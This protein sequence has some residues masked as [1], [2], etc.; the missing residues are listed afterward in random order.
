[1]DNGNLLLLISVGGLYVS[2]NGLTRVQ[3]LSATGKWRSAEASTIIRLKALGEIK[4]ET[5]V[6]ESAIE[7]GVP[8]AVHSATRDHFTDEDRAP[9]ESEPEAL[10]EAEPAVES[11][12]SH[13]TS[14]DAQA[15]VE[16]KAEAEAEPEAEADGED[17]GQPGVAAVA[18]SRQAR[19]GAAADA[20]AGLAEAGPAEPAPVEKPAPAAAAKPKPPASGMKAPAARPASAPRST[21][22][23][24]TGPSSRS[25]V[26]T[27]PPPWKILATVGVVSAAILL[28]LS[29]VNNLGQS[30]PAPARPA[31]PAAQI[32]PAVAEHRAFMRRAIELRAEPSARSPQ[33][34]SAARGVEVVRLGPVRSDGW[35]RI[36]LANRSEGY[37]LAAA[38]GDSAPPRLAAGSELSRRTISAVSTEVLVAPG[39]S[40]RMAILRSGQT[41]QVAGL[42][43]D[44]RDWVEVILDDGRVGY[45]QVRALRR[46]AS[47]PAA[48]PASGQAAPA[49]SRTAP[50]PRQ[51][52]PPAAQPAPAPAERA[53]FARTAAT[54]HADASSASRQIARAARGSSLTQIGEPGGTGWVR[55]RNEQGRTG[56]VRANVLADAR[57][58]ALDGA[59]VQ[60]LAVTA[61]AAPVYRRVG[62]E[63]FAEL[64]S[65][66]MVTVAGRLREHTAWVEVI[67]PNG[68]IGYMQLAAFASRPA[69]PA[70]AQTARPAAP[71]AG[72][73]VQADPPVKGPGL[74]AQ[75]DPGAAGSGADGASAGALPPASGPVTA[76]VWTRRPSG[77]DM[78]DAQPRRLMRWRR[79]EQVTFQCRFNARNR[80]EQCQVIAPSTSDARFHEWG[81]AIIAQYEA[82]P[83]DES[84][85]PVAGRLVVMPTLE[86]EPPR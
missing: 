8:A 21:A 63:T 74:A 9:F 47:R 86:F 85:Q 17:G 60:Q 6:R 36:R 79:A 22:Q 59:G 35:A 13:V 75:P 45:I 26:V 1:M 61:P 53:A 37:V 80:L 4:P 23:P 50:P 7:P 54:I 12:A 69:P 56:W 10:A 19:K 25:S 5:P 33:R 66:R 27:E 41:V 30:S 51:A 73:A 40:V 28:A 67:L 18:A 81:L 58:P 31:A 44:R 72:A 15:D 43:Q 64:P 14:A 68:D 76:P 20:A 32:A 55:V 24:Y 52:A 62:G 42:L 70:S 39:G 16:A 34:A 29:F 2:E 84:G 77:Q 46:P 57:P 83:L 78:A 11:G 48:A 71:G 49:P 3:F 65:G 82:R 38:L